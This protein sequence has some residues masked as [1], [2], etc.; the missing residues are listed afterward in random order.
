M[1]S[2]IDLQGS[3]IQILEGLGLPHGVAKVVWIPL[4]M[5]IIVGAVTVLAL[6]STWLERKISAAAQQRIGPEYMGPL[7]MLVPVADVVKLLFKENM[8]P[9]KTDP[10]LFVLAPILVFIPVFLSYL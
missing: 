4:P 5:V 6:V 9:A 8:L 1:S 7:G 10:W 2:G 3:F